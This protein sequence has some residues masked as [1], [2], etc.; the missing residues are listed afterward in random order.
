MGKRYWFALVAVLLPA[1][2]LAQGTIR[3]K[4]V[5]AKTGDPLPGANVIVVGQPYGGASDMSG[6]Y[7]IENVPPGVYQ[8]TASVIGYEKVT[9][10]VKVVAGV[11][12]VLDFELSPAAIEVASLE[13]VASRATRETPVAYSDVDKQVMEL[14]LGSRDIPLVLNTTPSVYA[15]TQGGGAGDARVN[16]RG[17]NQRNVAIMINGVPVNDMENGWVY[18]SNWDG[19]GDAT[20]SIQVQRG[21]SAINLATPSIGGTM[22][23]I[24]DPASHKR[25]LMYKQE[26][27]SWGFLKSTLGFNTGLINNSLALSGTIV[28]K[29]G[30]GFYKG[31]WTDAWAY[32]FGASYQASN[33][34]RFEFYALGAPQ[35][36]GQNLYKQN[37]A[38]YDSAFAASLLTDEELSYDA[39]SNGVGDYFEKFHAAGRDWNENYNT[40]DP[41]YD[42]VQYWT[43]YL[44]HDAEPRHAKDFLNEREN[45]FHKP[46]VNLNWYHTFSEKMNLATILY[47]SGGKGGGTGTYGHMVWDYSGP[48]RI[49]DWD[50]TIA[51]NTGNIDSTYSATESKS[52]GILRNS[53]NQQWTIGAISKLFYKVND[54]L[55]TQFGIDWR[56]A[57]IDHF[58][59]VRDL[60]GGDYYVYTY[61]DFDTTAEMQMKRLGD[62]I[63]YY[64]TNTVDWFGVFSQAEYKSGPISAYGVLGWS[65]IGYTFTDHFTKAAGDSL[66]EARGQ[67]NSKGELYA[68][69]K[70]LTGFQIKGGGMYKLSDNLSVYANLGYISKV[71]IFDNAINDRDGT[72]YENPKNEKFK[73]VEFGVNGSLM[74]GAMTYKANYYW[75]EWLD[76]SN[77]RGV[78]NADGSESYIFLTGMDAPHSGFEFEG[79]FQPMS[80]MRLDAALSLGNWRYISDVEGEY[81]TYTGGNDTTETYHYYVD[82]LKVGDAPQTQLALGF[83]LMPVKGFTAQVVYKFYADNYADWDPFSRTDSTDRAQSW[84]APDYSLVDLHISYDLPVHIG[85]MRLQAFAHVFNLLDAVYVQDAVD[86]SRYNAFGYW[87]G[88]TVPYFPHTA[89][90]AEVF[91]GLP[92]QWNVGLKLTF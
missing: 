92:R 20:S 28:R 82:G 81:K 56:T 60:L 74:N 63:A 16:V 70:G 66:Y 41:S 22:N 11:P 87:A 9:Q 18:W 38:A 51:Q 26:F 43:M 14:R 69:N 8:V 42:G 78:I 17:F 44:T 46:Q 15:T 23:I 4:V 40:V 31:T 67:V 2:V 53:C 73:S 45:Y 47:W 32:Y 35:R 27:G 84:K 55:K 19:V 48:S 71:P 83:S 52:E 89:S 61:N 54:N 39:D 65:T 24:T 76:R 1:L 59:E 86:N 72:V 91:L 21:L 49:V 90:A 10:E 25:G 13:V 36:H 7:V 62:K 75:T 33:T 77:L 58:R 3:G 5:D 85:G 88:R 80:L 50:A 30:D 68:E 37:V 34:D 29:I 57:E 64:N 6:N 12:A 79:A